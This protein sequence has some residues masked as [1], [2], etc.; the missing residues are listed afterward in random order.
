MLQSLGS[1]FYIKGVSDVSKV[2]GIY[3]LL[4]SNLS[5][6]SWFSILREGAPLNGALTH[7]RPENGREGGAV[8]V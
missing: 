6:F 2:F 5:S 4:Q 7:C 3:F 8:T 1:H